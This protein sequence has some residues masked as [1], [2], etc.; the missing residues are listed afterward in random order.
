MY[1]LKY[2]NINNYTETQIQTARGATLDD[3][4]TL[5]KVKDWETYRTMQ[6]T[7]LALLQVFRW[8]EVSMPA[9]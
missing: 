8:N 2:F 6:E 9:L 1:P 4:I 5:W 3:A 7:L